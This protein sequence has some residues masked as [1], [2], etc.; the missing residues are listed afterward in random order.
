MLPEKCNICV[1]V[2]SSLDGAF[3]Q[4]YIFILQFQ[5]S[6]VLSLWNKIETQ[7]TFFSWKYEKP[8]SLCFTC[9]VWLPV[10]S[11]KQPNYVRGKT[12]VKTFK[13]A[14]EE[15]QYWN[16]NFVF[17]C[18]PPAPHGPS[19]CSSCSQDIQIKVFYCDSSCSFV[20]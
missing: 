5:I 16:M 11:S 7:N 12:L 10:S 8:M 9:L 17:W 2:C 4:N 14:L 15:R 3:E 13:I 1:L 18:S 19:M 20:P 6:S